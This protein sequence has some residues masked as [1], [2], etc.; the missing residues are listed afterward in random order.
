LPRYAVS[1]S[2]GG[3]MSLRGQP[4]FEHCPGFARP[5]TSCQYMTRY[6][7]SY[8]CRKAPPSMSR[9]CRGLMRGASRLPSVGC[10]RKKSLY[11]GDSSDMGCKRDQVR[12][13][14]V[15]VLNERAELAPDQGY[16]IHVSRTLSGAFCTTTRNSM[17]R[18]Q[19]IYNNGIVPCPIGSARQRPHA[20]HLWH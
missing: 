4:I 15:H 2:D 20:G 3:R 17:R 7:I 11:S 1:N 5:L 12:Q 6:F 18:R 14:I 10:V 19:R 16:T 8:V 13:H 9:K